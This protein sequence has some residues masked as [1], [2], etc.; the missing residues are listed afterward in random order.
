MHIKYY[1]PA[2]LDKRISPGFYLES[3][4]TGSLLFLRVFTEAAHSR[5]P[6]PAPC[7]FPLLFKANGEQTETF[8]VF[9]MEN[10]SNIR[11]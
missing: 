11:W 7:V 6:P 3:R 1:A 4:F 10:R 2:S 8:G 5:A 9:L